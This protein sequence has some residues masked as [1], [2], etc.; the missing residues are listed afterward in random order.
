MNL[1]FIFK[2]TCVP[3]PY[4]PVKVNSMGGGCGLGAGICQLNPSPDSD[5]W[6]IFL[7]RDRAI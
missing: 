2:N 1:D 3:M 7:P 6:Q 4:A 5:I